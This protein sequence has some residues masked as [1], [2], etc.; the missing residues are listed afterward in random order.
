MFAAANWQLLTGSAYEKW[1]AYG[2]SAPYY[3]LLSD[4]ARAGQFLLWNPWIAGGSPDFAVAGSGTFSPDLL[5]YA[6]VAGPGQQWYVLYW[7]LVWI[8]GGFGMLLLA[9]HFRVPAW[10]GLIVAMG[11]VFSGFYTGHSEH[12]SVVYSHSMLP[13]IIWRLDL[14]LIQRRWITAAQA[15]VLFGLS[16]LTGYAEL[17]LGTG[18]VAVT[19]TLGRLVFADDANFRADWRR[20][21]LLFGIFVAT[22]FVILSP[23]LFAIVYETGG[24]S[25]RSAPLARE[26]ALSSNALHPAAVASLSSPSMAALKLAQPSRWAYT[27]V[28]SLSVYTGSATLLLAAL[29][30]GAKKAR[31]WN[32]FIFGCGVAALACAMS[33]TFP[34]RGWLYDLVPP[35]KY[36]RHASMLRGYFVFSLS[37]LAIGG[38]KELARIAHDSMLWRRLAHASIVIGFLG[39]GGFAAIVLPAPAS[40]PEFALA[41]AHC[42]AAWSLPAMAAMFVARRPSRARFLPAVLVLGAIAD[43]LGSYSLAA[44]IIR[45]VGPRPLLAA[46]ATSSLNLGAEQFDRALGT[47]SGNLNLIS[48]VPSFKSYAPLKNRFYELTATYPQLGILAIGERRIWF[49]EDVPQIGMSR[50]IFDEYMSKVMHDDAPLFVRH[51][52]ETMAADYATK[53]EDLLALKDAPTP[54]SLPSSVSLYTPRKLVLDTTAPADGWLMV[55]ERWARSWHATINGTE[56]PVLGANFIFRA[57]PVRKGD[58]HVE[59][60]YRPPG[61]VALVTTSWGVVGLIVLLSMPWRQ[62]SRVGAFRPS[63][64]EG[65]PQWSLAAK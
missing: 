21:G 47:S 7:L 27:D 38:F 42:L 32:W 61:I 62:F 34:L 55:T 6:A 52:R 8:S 36:F 56:E 13:L 57:L 37:L 41:T 60:D 50:R 10:A 17:T 29:A 16:G 46:P 49:A 53:D 9:R 19:W 63:R 22:A 11:Y 40:Y 51:A 2:L 18:L 5:L 25:D 30:L 3:A 45:D 59:F 58:V 39:L 14:A 28:S 20:S 4:F 33:Q 43:G 35:A 31:R 44:D 15:G 64:G 24:Y 1:D 54:V 65:Q 23:S 12:L 48:K 26:F